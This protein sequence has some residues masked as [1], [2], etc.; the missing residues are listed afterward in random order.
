VFKSLLNLSDI[1]IWITVKQGLRCHN[2]PWGAI[3]A[4]YCA[5]KD[6]GLLDEVRIIGRAETF[7]G[8]DFCTIKILYFLEAGSNR[9]PV[10]NDSTSTAL[11][12]SITGLFCSGQSEILSQQIKKN[13]VRLNDKLI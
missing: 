6:K 7:Y 4:L 10:Y 9:F 8:D 5:R 11:P 12:F 3:P 2:H 1:W 13:T